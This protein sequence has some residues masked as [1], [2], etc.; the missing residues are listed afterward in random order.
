MDRF[1]DNNN[2][3]FDDQK[4]LKNDANR[5]EFSKQLDEQ[6]DE[7]LEKKNSRDQRN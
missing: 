4:K 3:K 6:F 5:V 7:E 2:K 1:K